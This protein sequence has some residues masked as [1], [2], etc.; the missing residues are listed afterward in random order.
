M[1][2]DITT[3]QSP[4]NKSLMVRAA[5][6]V[7]VVGALALVLPL[8]WFAFLSTLGLLGIGITA[9][10]GFGLVQAIPAL[11][12]KWENKLLGLRKAEARA[13]PIEQI[14]NNVIRLR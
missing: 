5:V 10:I 13:N 4:P 8:V 1:A 9:V 6:A 14:Q 12:Q 11:G 2:S 3:A 7:G